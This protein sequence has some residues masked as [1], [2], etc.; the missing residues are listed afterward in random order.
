MDIE[1]R[2][3]RVIPSGTRGVSVTLKGSF[4]SDQEWREA[5]AKKAG[6]PTLDASFAGEKVFRLFPWW[7]E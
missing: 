4:A 5:A 2:V 7:T 3:Y 6:Y 1:T